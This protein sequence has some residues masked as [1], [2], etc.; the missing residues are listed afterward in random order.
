MPH[1]GPPSCGCRSPA[2]IAA[3]AFWSR[4]GWRSPRR[5]AYGARGYTASCR[6][7][8][9]H[10]LTGYASG[11]YAWHGVATSY[12]LGAGYDPLQP[13]A[14]IGADI[15]VL[16]LASPVPGERVATLR[17]IDMPIAPGTRLMLGGFSQDRAEV[18]I[19][20]R[21]CHA[22]S[23]ARDQQG[24]MLLRH[25]CTAT[26][27]TSGAPLLATLADG[28]WGVAGVQVAALI[29]G[30]GGEAVAAETLRAMLP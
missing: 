24:S 5:I 6:P 14:T 12:R 17:L 1:H 22:V 28:I 27:G 11:G 21:T 13:Y 25:S 20:D 3:P 16:V 15:A 9:V 19:A 23:N 26:H 10:V 7:R 8:S 4:R 29:G 2:S 18:L 30:S